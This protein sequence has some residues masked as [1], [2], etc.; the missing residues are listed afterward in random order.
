MIAENL[1]ALSSIV[2]SEVEDITVSRLGA[3]KKALRLFALCASGAALLP[4]LDQTRVRALRGPRG[5][6]TDAAGT[7][8]TF[9]VF[10]LRKEEDCRLAEERDL[11][12]PPHDPQEERTK[13]ARMIEAA[14]KERMYAEVFG[15]VLKMFMFKPM[16]MS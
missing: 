12:L 11:V 14:Q 5:G 7:A 1:K 4:G 15:V 13:L 9:L 10:L 3:K 2:S 16:A 6:F 8:T